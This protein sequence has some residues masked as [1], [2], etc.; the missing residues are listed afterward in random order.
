METDPEKW[1][2][3]K[4]T[5]LYQR[6]LRLCKM[7]LLRGNP[8][9]QRKALETYWYIF[10]HSGPEPGPNRFDLDALMQPPL[11]KKV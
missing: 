2:A 10:Q 1:E 6:Y 5:E 7:G 11:R 8:E 9:K 3:F 4:R